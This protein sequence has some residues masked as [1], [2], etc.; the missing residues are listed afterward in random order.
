MVVRGAE[1]GEVSETVEGNGVLWGREADGTGVSGD[2]A[3]L[4][5]IRGLGT[6][7]EAVPAD[8]G[9]GGEGWALEEVYGSPGVEGGLLVDGGE[10]SRLA[11][12]GW[13]E[14]GSKV[15]LEAL[16]DKVLELNLGS[17][18]VGGGPGLA[19]ESAMCLP[20]IS[21]PFHPPGSR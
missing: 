6:D 9:V 14:R 16:G 3:G 13:V 11:A 8:D 19:C 12:L 21:C 1:G 7:K 4:D 15:E 20:W 2:S 18:D 17:K 5:V 10:D